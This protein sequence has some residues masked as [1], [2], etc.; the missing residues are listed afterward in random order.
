M[1]DAYDAAASNDVLAKATL[2]SL[3]SRVTT[4]ADLT[5]RADLDYYRVTLP[6][7]GFGVLSVSVKTSGLSLLA[8]KLVVYD[9]AGALVASVSA[10]YGNDAMLRLTGLTPGKSY[11]I[12]VDG[13]SSDVFGMGAYTLDMFVPTLCDLDMDGQ[14]TASDYVILDA[15]LG[16]TKANWLTGDADGDSRVITGFWMRTW[17]ARRCRA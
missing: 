6:A 16:A 11:P 8:P 7:G 3:S 14:V 5:N 17:A 12:M 1:A 10:S 15:D 13:A 4:H 9:S 2:L